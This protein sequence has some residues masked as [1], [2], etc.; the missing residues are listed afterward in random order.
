MK[1][2]LRIAAPTVYGL[3]PSIDTGKDFLPSASHVVRKLLVL[4]AA[5]PSFCLDSQHDPYTVY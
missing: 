1:K 2:E 5:L 3:G 4:V